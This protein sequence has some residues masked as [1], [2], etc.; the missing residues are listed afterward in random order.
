MGRPTQAQGASVVDKSVS[1]LFFFSSIIIVPAA[2]ASPIRSSYHHSSLL[3]DHN[4]HSH[5]NDH[6]GGSTQAQGAL[7]VGKSAYN[8][9]SILLNQTT[10]PAFAGNWNRYTLQQHNYF[11]AIAFQ[12]FANVNQKDCC[13]HKN[14]Q[15]SQKQSFKGSTLYV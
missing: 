15:I 10:V 1:N 2:K 14:F 11:K 3:F 4:H 12:S 9:L 6:H 5:H 13:R 8:L 7:A